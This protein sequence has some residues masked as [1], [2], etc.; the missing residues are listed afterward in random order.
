[1]T[2]EIKIGNRLLGRHRPCFI[3]A[4]AGVNHN[5][6]IRLARQLID[7]AKQAGVDAIKFQSYTATELVTARGALA[8]YQ[9]KNINRQISQQKMLTRLELSRSD[10][11]QL[12]NYC[13]RKKIIFLS[14]PHSPDILGW[15]DR[16]VPAFKIGSGD[17]T[18]TPFLSA[19]AKLRKPILL[20]T[21]MATMLEI[22]IAVNTI[23]KQSNKQIVA[24][25][26]TTSYPCPLD[27]VNLSA[28]TNIGQELNILTGYSDHTN[29]LLVPVMAVTL[30]AV[31]IEKHFT[32]NKKMPGPDHQASLNP[33]ELKKMVERI[34]EAQHA[35]GNGRKQ[36]QPTE[37]ENQVNV[38]KSLIAQIAIAPGTII[39]RQMIAI[40]RPGSGLPPS[41]IDRIIGRQARRAIKKDALLKLDH[42]K[43]K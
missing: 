28:M 26:C 37:R 1:M 23:K 7:Q 15:L 36:V 11:I 24:L 6:D 33:V 19:V 10:F 42:F 39:T 20:G 3:I 9:R 38:R 16:L 40:K 35:L 14:T 31:I 25:H 30:G 5:G 18:N 27:Q 43:Q 29:G 21:G 22:K 2:S 4:E 32:L 34:R 8:A 41:Q 17:L 13:D 12:K